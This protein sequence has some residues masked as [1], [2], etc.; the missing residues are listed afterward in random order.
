MD[1]SPAQSEAQTVMFAAVLL[2][3]L[4]REARRSK[5]H[6]SSLTLRMHAPTSR[7][8]GSKKCTATE[9]WFSGGS[10]NSTCS[11]MTDHRLYRCL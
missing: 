1:V 6:T 7:T 10:G 3:L 8:R 2:A 5:L 11:I 4:A 9:W